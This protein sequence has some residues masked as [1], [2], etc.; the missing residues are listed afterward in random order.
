[1][2]YSDQEASERQQQ[3]G[4]LFS[5]ILRAASIISNGSQ[6]VCGQRIINQLLCECCR[7]ACSSSFGTALRVRLQQETCVATRVGR[8]CAAVWLWD[9]C[10]WI[11]RLN[12][13]APAW[14]RA[15]F[16]LWVKQVIQKP[17]SITANIVQ[18]LL[19]LFIILPPKTARELGSARAFKGNF[20]FYELLDRTK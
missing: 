1:M 6:R 3:F 13:G 10:T 8:C 18:V 19:A 9:Q 14:F 11:I 7:P 4:S 5:L 15:C 16:L 20:T 2:G 17:G 12:L